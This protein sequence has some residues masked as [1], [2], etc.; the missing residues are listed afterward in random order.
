MILSIYRTELYINCSSS[1]WCAHQKYK[2][3]E[4]EVNR[5]DG[6]ILLRE[7][8]GEVKNFMDFKMNAVMV[9]FNWFRLV[10]KRAHKYTKRARNLSPPFISYLLAASL[11]AFITECQ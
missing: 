2:D 4:G 7:L 3:L 10:M 1:H 9:S 11:P 6:I 8:A 5:K